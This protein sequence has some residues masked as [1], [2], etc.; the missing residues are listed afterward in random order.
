[1][2][3]LLGNLMVKPLVLLRLVYFCL[4]IFNLGSADMRWNP[5]MGSIAALVCMALVPEFFTVIVYL[6][7]G[8]TMGTTEV[9]EASVNGRDS[10]S[11]KTEEGEVA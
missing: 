10:G 8:F 5:L 7:T 6:W 9:A 11:R 2:Q 4:A 1:M 3:I